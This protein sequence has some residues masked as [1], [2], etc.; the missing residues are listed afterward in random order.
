MP[1]SN[2]GATGG[3]QPGSSLSLMLMLE[4][5]AGPDAGPLKILVVDDDDLVRGS[6]VRML[7]TQGYEVFSADGV[8]AALTAIARSGPFPVVLSDLHMPGTGGLPFLDR[9]HAEHPDSAVLML[10]GDSDVD[11]A[12]A[13][14]KR[15]ASDYLTKPVVMQELHAR[16]EQAL[17][18]RR[19]QRELRHFRERYQN[20]LE[21]QVRE[22]AVRNQRMF[23][24]QVYMAVRMLEAKDAYTSGHS[25]RVASYAVRTG[26]QLGLDAATL[27]EVR[28]GAELHDIGKIGTRDAVLNK[29]GPLDAAEFLEMQAH[30]IDG[31]EMLSVLR[32]EHPMVLQIV[33]SHHERMDGR[34]F[35]DRLIG[36]A[37]PLVARLVCVVDAFDAM[38]STRAYREKADRLW[39]REELERHRGVQFDP[40]IL[41]A[42][43]ATFPDHPNFSPPA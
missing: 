17:N 34:G 32:D 22:L 23:L 42:F 31:E 30:T 18:N 21:R 26:E 15:G 29:P 39:A 37:I 36:D 3:E 20:D 16:V 2:F 13:C 28:L 27:E 6:L 1:C 14:L 43:F 25:D 12:V 4:P 35:P 24:G 41:D 40:N 9:L 5:P 33:R 8:D 19:L 10:T 7:A 38:T 11:M